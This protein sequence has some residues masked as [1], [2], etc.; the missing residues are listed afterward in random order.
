MPT[1]RNTC[2]ATAFA[3]VV[4]FGLS[5][6]YALAQQAQ[7]QPPAQPGAQ[8][9]QYSDDQIEAF[10]RASLDVAEIRDAYEG[11]IADAETPQAAEDL[12]REANARMVATLE[13][14]GLTVDEYNGIYAAMQANPEVNNRV[15]E[16]LRELTG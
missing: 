5:A 6:P 7:P 3:A 12:L 2:L 11:R 9:M 13:D 14:Y 15:M 1:L 16:K 8:Q 4:S 10:V